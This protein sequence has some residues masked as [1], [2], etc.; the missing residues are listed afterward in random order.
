MKKHLIKSVMPGSIAE[1]MGI[2]AGDYLICINDEEVEDVF[3][4]RFLIMNEK[5]TLVI[6]K[7]FSDGDEEWEIEIEKDGDSLCA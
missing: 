3:D 4:Y 6:E 7:G 1:N 2:E 5:I